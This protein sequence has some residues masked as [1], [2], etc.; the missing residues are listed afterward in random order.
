MP[1]NRVVTATALA[2]GGYIL[3]KQI[4]KQGRAGGDQVIEESIELKVPRHLAYEQWMRVEDF[5]SFMQSVKEVRRIDPRHLHWKA[6]IGGRELE[7]DAEITAQVP[8][9]RIA[10]RS[11]GAVHD[12]GSVSF[13]ALPG[14]HTRITIKM[15]YEADGAAEQLGD[16]FSTVRQETRANLQRFK[17]MMEAK[18]KEGGWRGQLSQH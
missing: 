10:W 1:L 14:E 11:T 16:M 2:V 17:E 8:D 18:G 6:Q 4:S 15:M 7:W 13:T 12:R 9:R 5:P 3:S